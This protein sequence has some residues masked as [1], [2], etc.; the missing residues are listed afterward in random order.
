MRRCCPFAI[1]TL[2]LLVLAE[3]AYAD[4]WVASWTGAVHGP[5]PSGNPTAQLELKFAF[6]VAEQGAKD[7]TF[8]LI[9]RP[10]LWGRQSRIRLPS[11][12]CNG[13]KG[14]AGALSTM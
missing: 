12:S 1:I 7:Q 9:I 2:I 11:G 4:K 3:S 6:P 14:R 13:P 8:R 5:Y 10:D